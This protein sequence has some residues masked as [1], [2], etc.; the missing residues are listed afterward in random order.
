MVFFTCFVLLGIWIGD[1]FEA[2]STSRT[3]FSYF[4]KSTTSETIELYVFCSLSTVSFIL[5]LSTFF[6]DPKVASSVGGL[7]Y[8]AISIVSM[9][10]TSQKREEIYYIVCLFPQSALTLGVRNGSGMYVE[11]F[12]F[13]RIISMVLFDFFLYLI[14]YLYLDQVV[15]DENGVRKPLLFF[16]DALKTNKESAASSNEVP[17][18]EMLM[19]SENVQSDFSS[20]KF[21]EM[22]HGADY[23]KK[24][25]QIS[26]LTKKF[27]GFTAVDNISFPIYEGQ[28]FCL[29]GHNGAGKTTTINMLTGLLEIDGGKVVYDEEDL[30]ENMEKVRSKIG[31][32]TQHDILFE[33]LRVCEHLE[34]IAKLRKLPENDIPAAVEEALRKVNLV[35]ERDKFSE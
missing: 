21:H 10:A 18:K 17:M 12:S 16:L 11:G 27:G 30:A 4:I 20:A 34:L 6:S 5:S 8:A 2:D 7:L 9:I 13:H 33:K 29:L 23:L 15:K 1:L 22:I 26:N 25:V 19:S 24:S 28:I 31:V 14:L 32:C 35:N 3:V